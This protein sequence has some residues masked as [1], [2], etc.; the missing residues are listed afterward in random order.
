M[1]VRIILPTLFNFFSP[2]D[3]PAVESPLGG[4]SGIVSESSAPESTVKSV[5]S[6]GRGIGFLAWS[7]IAQLSAISM[8]FDCQWVEFAVG[9]RDE[10]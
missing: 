1:S 4:V 6:W 9:D 3:P 7:S 5:I 2:P 10:L 8:V